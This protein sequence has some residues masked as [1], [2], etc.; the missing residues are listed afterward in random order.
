MVEK[1]RDDSGQFSSEVTDDDILAA[2]RAHEPAATSEIAG[3]VGMSR[4]GTDR[5]LRR[6]RDAG[7]V[8]SKKIAASLVW[9]D[10]RPDGAIE[11]DEHAQERGDGDRRGEQP[12]PGN[13]DSDAGVEGDLETMIENVDL[14]GSGAKLDE[15]REALR[16]AIEY[17]VEQGTAR[18]SDFEEDVYPEFEARYETSYSWWKNAIGPALSQVA[19]KTEAI[20]AADHA[21]DWS[22]TPGEGGVQ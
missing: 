8:S 7:R 13:D 15:R 10:A 2:V 17:L 6:L 16:A 21:G 1:Q 5:R 9:F 11:G 19:S 4:Q 3:E 14:P 22:F 18:R 20:E 12:A